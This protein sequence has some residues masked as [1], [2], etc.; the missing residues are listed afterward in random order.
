MRQRNTHF[1]PKNAAA[2]I[3]LAGFLQLFAA[4]NDR[5]EFGRSGGAKNF[6]YPE[7]FSGGYIWGGVGMPE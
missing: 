5:T 1:H 2:L 7:N 3:F 6:G 4:Q